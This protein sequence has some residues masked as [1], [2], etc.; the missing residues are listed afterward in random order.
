MRV[1]ILF[2]NYGPYH[3]SRVRAAA[4]TMDVLAVEC[5]HVSKVYQWRPTEAPQ[6]LRRANIQ[7]DVTRE[8]TWDEAITAVEREFAHFEPAAIAVPGWSSAVSLSALMWAGRT[9]VPVVVMSESN[10]FDFARF[11]PIE[12]FKSLIVKR[13]SAGICGGRA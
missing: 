12:S 10:R 13:F 2:D 4:A 1:A 3:L 9:G 8:L 5:R 7:V 6:D 11:D